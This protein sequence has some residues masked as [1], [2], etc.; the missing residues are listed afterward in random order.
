MHSAIAMAVNPV[1]IWKE[2]FKRAALSFSCVF[3]FWGGDSLLLPLTDLQYVSVPSRMSQTISLKGSLMAPRVLLKLPG[4]RW[5]RK[6]K[7]MRRR[8]RKRMNKKK[9]TVDLSPCEYLRVGSALID[10]PLTQ[11]VSVALIRFNYPIGSWSYLSLWKCSSNCQWF[12]LSG[13]GCL[14][15]LETVS[16]LYTF[17]NIFKIK[18]LSCSPHSV[19]FAVGVTRH[20]KTFL[21]FFFLICKVVC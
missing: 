18:R 12:T 8:G 2:I 16:K 17:P 9:K 11:D 6:T 13:H 7:R 10:T 15:H 4:K 1:W 5:K 20:L 14:E 3:S 19:H 21:A